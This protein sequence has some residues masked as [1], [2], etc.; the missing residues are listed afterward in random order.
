MSDTV[1][2]KKA[3]TPKKYASLYAIGTNWVV[4]RIVKYP[5]LRWLYPFDEPRS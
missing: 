1:A 3:A 4:K 5:G 2:R